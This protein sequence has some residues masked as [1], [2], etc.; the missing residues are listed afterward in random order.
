MTATAAPAPARPSAT[1]KSATAKTAAKTPGAPPT[2]PELA[3]P[4]L[5]GRVPKGE[6]RE[7]P[8]SSIV[9]PPGTPDRLERPGDQERIAETARSLREVGQLQPIMV[10]QSANPEQPGRFVRVFGRRRLAAA[11]LNKAETILAIVVPPLDSEVRRTIGAVENIQRQ[12]LT[13]SEEHLAVWELLELSAIDAAVRVR[14][15]MPGG[16]IS[17]SLRSTSSD[18]GDYP[19]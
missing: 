4:P 3:G 1:A 2:P 11:R 6:L 18:E 12:D 17:R 13:P 19:R 7:L 8:I 10:E 5:L 16:R 15:T 14:A 9:D